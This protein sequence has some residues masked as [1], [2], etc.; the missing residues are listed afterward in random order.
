MVLESGVPCAGLSEAGIEHNAKLNGIL[1]ELTSTND[2]LYF[3]RWILDEAGV[4]RQEVPRDE[5]IA[6][7]N[8]GRRSVGMQLF[9]QAM[10]AG[11]AEKIVG[12][13]VN[14]G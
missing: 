7:W 4:F 11:F 2:G 8:A 12:R 5:R 6:I 3:L 10:R 13:D 1:Q 9:S 14:N